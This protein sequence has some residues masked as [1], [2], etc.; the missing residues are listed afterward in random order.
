MTDGGKLVSCGGTCYQCKNSSHHRW[1]S[2][3]LKCCID[4]K[5]LPL[6]MDIGKLDD[7]NTRIREQLQKLVERNSLH[8]LAFNEMFSN[9][10]LLIWKNDLMHNEIINRLQNDDIIASR[11]A[12]VA[13]VECCK[14]YPE[15]LTNEV[16]LEDTMRFLTD[17]GKGLL[18]KMGRQRVAAFG[19]GGAIL[20]LELC[21]KNGGILLPMAE[22]D[23]LLL[24]IRNVTDCCERTIHRFYSKRT[25][26]PALDE[27]F[28]AVKDQPKTGIC[29]YCFERK[30]RCK[31]GVCSFCR[32][33]QYCSKKCLKAHWSE[34]QKVCS[35]FHV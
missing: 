12:I 17:N 18:L 10:F 29:D 31:L 20:Y 26:S 23:E 13:L 6:H 2:C 16:Y 25:N 24:K 35:R 30:E 15:I 3:R 5:R 21:Q 34:H 4:K 7:V 1:D 22:T 33:Q 28:A 9:T 11:R 27:K 8:S 19:I 14:M 32:E